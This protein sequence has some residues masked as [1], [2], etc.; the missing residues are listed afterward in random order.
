MTWSEVPTKSLVVRHCRSSGSIVQL[1]SPRRMFGQ[2]FK[3]NFLHFLRSETL[4]LISVS[5]TCTLMIRRATCPFESLISTAWALP[6][7]IV[8]QFELGYLV[9]LTKVLIPPQEVLPGLQW[10]VNPL[11]FITS[12]IMNPVSCVSCRQIMSK[13]SHAE[14]MGAILV[15]QRA[16]Q[17]PFVFHVPIE[18]GTENRDLRGLIGIQEVDTEEEAE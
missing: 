10:F 8:L 1:K 11:L 9:D 7:T 14:R 18:R 16:P 6:S 12:L 17:T 5:K 13:L 4:A 3:T 15:S 2:E